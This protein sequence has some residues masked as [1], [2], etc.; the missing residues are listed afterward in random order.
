MVS[1]CAWRALPPCFAMSKSTD[2]PAPLDDAGLSDVTRVV[3]DTAHVRAIKGANT[4]V[5]AP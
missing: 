2:R 3:L 4:Q 5:R 1:G